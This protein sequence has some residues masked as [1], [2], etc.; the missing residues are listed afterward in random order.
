MPE[1]RTQEGRN[2]ANGFLPVFLRVRKMQNC[3]KTIT[4]RLLRILQL[5]DCSLSADSTK[6]EMLLIEMVTN[7]N[8]LKLN[9]R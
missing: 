9:T 7:C 4:R 3:S 5:W 1:L 2:N 6:Q 8:H